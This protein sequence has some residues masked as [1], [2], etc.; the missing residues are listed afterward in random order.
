METAVDDG[1]PDGWTE[2]KALEFIAFHMRDE[3]TLFAMMF[4]HGDWR[5]LQQFFPEFTKWMKQ[6]N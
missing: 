4:I 1:R 6:W 2:A 3:Q 5:G